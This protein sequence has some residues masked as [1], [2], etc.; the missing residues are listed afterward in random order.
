MCY[1]GAVL[2]SCDRQTCTSDSGMPDDEWLY[3]TQ[4]TGPFPERW[5]FCSWRCMSMFATENFRPSF[6]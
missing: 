3:V 1:D 4:G 6:L 2:V 5:T